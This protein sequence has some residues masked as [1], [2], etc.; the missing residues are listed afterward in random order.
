MK[1]VQKLMVVMA[2]TSCTA[3]KVYDWAGW[4]DGSGWQ[5][6]VDLA[7]RDAKLM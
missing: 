2:L 4:A 6:N 7:A 3:A 1:H 5:G